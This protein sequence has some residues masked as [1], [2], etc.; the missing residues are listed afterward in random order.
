M[1]HYVKMLKEGAQADR[2][3]QTVEAEVNRIAEASASR[4]RLVPLDVRLGRLLATIPPEVQ[5]DGL[6]LLSLVTM[7][8][9]RRG[10]TCHT[11]E[12]GRALRRMG[13]TRVRCW[14]GGEDGGFAA[15]WHPPRAT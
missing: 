8:K 1:S 14:R 10:G 12:L 11:G 2:A 15:L 5:H 7:L 13:W 9:G 3:R 4:D 6:S